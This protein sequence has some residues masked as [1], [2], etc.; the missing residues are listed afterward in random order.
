MSPSRWTIRDTV[1]AAVR[2]ARRDGAL[3]ALTAV[4]A[5]V[6]LIL[7]L[8][9]AWGPGGRL[10]R[11]AGPLVLL[12]VGL[13][14]A[15]ALGW[16]LARRWVRAV[17]DAAVAAAAERRRGLPE[18][19]LR[20]VLELGRD[21]PAGASAALVRRSEADLTGRLAGVDARP[22]KAD[23]LDR[24]ALR[25]A[26]RGADLVF[27]TAGYVG[28]QPVDRVWRINALSPRLVVEAAAAEDVRRVVLTSSIAAI[29]PAP[30]GGVADEEQPYGARS[31]GLTYA[32]AKREGE[33]EAFLTGVRLGVEVVVVNPSYVFGV[34]LDRSQ[35]GETSTRIVGNYL[36]GRLPAV[37]NGACNAVDVED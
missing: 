21:L 16:W 10:V 24:G 35:A 3:A 36:R 1:E 31:L 32:D 33:M 19:S 23:T 9:W 5:L 7:L 2:R 14:G 11:G 30:D 25:R 12:T 29:G 18:G 26:L 27:H 37:V 17:D 15:S 6:P 13:A 28:S 20:G 34:P 4:A 8:V 22:V